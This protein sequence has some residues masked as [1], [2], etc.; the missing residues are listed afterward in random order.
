MIQNEKNTQ[1][2]VFVHANGF[3]P[4]SYKILLEKI[5]KKFNIFSILLN[6]DSYEFGGNPFACIKC[7]LFDSIII[8]IIY[9]IALYHFYKIIINSFLFCNFLNYI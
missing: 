7:I 4:N 5:S 3:P 8:I 2:L 6:K 9:L 1:K